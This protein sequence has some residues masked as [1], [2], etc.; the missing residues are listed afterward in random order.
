M[1]TSTAVIAGAGIGGLAAA[2]ALH[3]RGW[4]VLVL[5]RAARVEPV[6]AGI[7]LAPNAL[8]GLDTLGVGEKI[9]ALAAI[10]GRGGVRRPDGRWLLRTDLDMVAERFGDP[11]VIAHRA[12]LVDLLRDRLP[13]GSVRLG[14]EVTGV[15]PG[16]ERRQAEVTT[17]DGARFGADL[18]VAADG[19]WSTIRS[20]TFP[21]VPRPSYA[22]FTTWRFVAPAPAGGFEPSETWGRGMVFGVTPLSGGRVY[23]YAAANL[24][25]GVR[26]DDERA[27]L[28]DRFGA[29]HA[30]I[31]DLLRAVPAD[32][33]RNDV[34]WMPTAPPAYH[35]GRVALLGDAAHAMTP[36]LG[37]GGCQAIED[38]VVLGH[39]AAT[40][41]D[42]PTALAGYTAA[43]LPRATD[44]V[45][46][47]RRMGR[48]QQWSA[49]PAVAIRDGG[50]RL[51]ARL[52]TGLMLRQLAPVVDWTP[53]A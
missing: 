45:R 9:R 41:A 22:T 8:R 18:V 39:L 6:G 34:Y 26:Y 12:E 30:P 51:S 50:I 24:P 17:D 37:Q 28:A 16:D 43:R 11:I 27:A 38:A 15:T 32:V 20:L 44:M 13:E 49:R 2:V 35:A 40:A 36:N 7:S 4:Q 29:W 42:V 23:C 31:P 21:A 25:E 47:S 46:R 5:E 1:A 48:V 10:Q 33:L 53:P 14:A 52:G 19:V 3:Q